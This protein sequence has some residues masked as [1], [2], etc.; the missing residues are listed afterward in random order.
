MRE[1]LGGLRRRLPDLIPEKEKDLVA[2]LR[3]ALHAEKYPASDTRQGRPARWPRE[4]LLR[5][6]SLLRAVLGRGTGGRKDA[7]TFVDH[8]LPLLSFPR[9][10]VGALEGGE[11]TLFEAGQLARISPAKL[12]VSASAARSERSRLLRAHLDSREPCGRLRARVAALLGGSAGGGS[13]ESPLPSPEFPPDVLS[14][15]AQLEAE[16]AAAG[17]GPGDG[18]APGEADPG[19]L[20]FD[21]LRLIAEA[22]REVRPEDLTD[23][24]L[25]RLYASGDEILLIL[26]RVRKRQQ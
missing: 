18:E 3:A 11:V 6:M 8:Y 21:H 1:V 14:A 17:H 25:E 16:L 10:V 13:A 4:E 20:F 22:L 9:D 5:V 24:V 19:H 2:L 7:R 12:G 23:G 15:A 26:Q